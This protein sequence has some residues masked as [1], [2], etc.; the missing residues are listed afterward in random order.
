MQTFIYRAPDFWQPILQG[1]ACDLPDKQIDI[2]KR[3]LASVRQRHGD[4]RLVEWERLPGEKPA[5][6]AVDIYPL[7]A[8]C[9]DF[10]F[11]KD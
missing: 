1:K 2:A 6:D 5:H 8:V 11:V 10:V 3:F 9:C 4:V 7:A